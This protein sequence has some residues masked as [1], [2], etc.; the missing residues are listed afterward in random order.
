MLFFFFETYDLKNP[1]NTDHD[2][3]IFVSMMGVH[4]FGDF[5]TKIHDEDEEEEY[6]NHECP[7]VCLGPFCEETMISFE[8]F[9]LKNRKSTDDDEENTSK[10]T[11]FWYTSDHIWDSF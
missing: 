4:E 10:N 5:P 11:R 6:R 2:K 8:V 3:T 9:C 1:K 7:S